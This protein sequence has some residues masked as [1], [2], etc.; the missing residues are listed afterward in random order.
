MKSILAIL[1]FGLTG[2]ASLVAQRP[3]TLQQLQQI[4][5]TDQDCG[6]IDQWVDYSE[7]QLR[8][9]GLLDARPEDLNNEDRLYNA[10][11]RIIV[12]SLRIDCNNPKRYSS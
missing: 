1:V 4:R 8:L 6:K 9:K 10:T 2:C 11:A 5:L 12:W 7:K 3:A